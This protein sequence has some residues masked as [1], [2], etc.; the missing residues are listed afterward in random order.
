MTIYK[1]GSQKWFQDLIWF[2]CD[3]LFPDCYQVGTPSM[4]SYQYV[5]Y[6]FIEFKSK[7]V[8]L[9]QDLFL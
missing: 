2:M 4:V 3:S 8:P 9:L 5:Y 6:L 1:Y 7:K